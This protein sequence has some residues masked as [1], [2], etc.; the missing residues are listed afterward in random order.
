[1]KQFACICLS[2]LALTASAQLRLT[3]LSLTVYN[4]NF[5]VVRDTVPLDLKAGANTVIY[6]GATAQVERTPSSCATSR[7]AFASNPGTKLSKRSGLPE[8]LLS[9]F[10]GKTIDFQEDATEGKN[11]ETPELVPANRPQRLRAGGQYQQPIIEVN[12]KMQF[13]LPGEPLFP[14]SRDDNG[15]EARL[16]LAV[17]I[18]QG[19]QVDAEVG[20]VTGGFVGASYNLVC[21][22]VISGH[23]RLDYDEQQQRQNVRERQI[24]LMPAT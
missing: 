22:R 17:A 11:T 8:L 4:Q 15:V 1:M 13:S 7:P 2:G 23:R 14:R 5:A 20:Y 24:K 12:G 9:L 18:R 6:S 10:E 21:G 16:Q 3:N 19:W